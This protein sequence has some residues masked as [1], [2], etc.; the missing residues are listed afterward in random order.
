M[1]R[2]QQGLAAIQEAR[3]KLLFKTIKIGSQCLLPCEL[4]ELRFFDSN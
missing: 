2:L 4:L 3:F 1:K